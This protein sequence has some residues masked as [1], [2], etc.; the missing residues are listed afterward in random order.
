[1]YSQG[2]ALGYSLSPLWGWEGYEA[3]RVIEARASRACPWHPLGVG[4]MSWGGFL[5]GGLLLEFFGFFYGFVYRADVHEG[6]FGEGVVFAVADFFEAA[7]G[8]V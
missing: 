6:L 4:W 1:M 5:G 3:A 8:V 7:D 2:F